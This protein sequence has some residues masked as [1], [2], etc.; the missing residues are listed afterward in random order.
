MPKG[1]ELR[2]GI[3][4]LTSVLIGG[5]IA[6]SVGSE[7]NLFDSKT[8]YRVVFDTV[9]GLR[10]GSPVQIAGVA[11]GSVQSVD[12]TDSGEIEVRFDVLSDAT[13]LIR[14]EPGAEAQKDAPPGTPTGSIASLQGK[15][16]LGDM[17]LAVSVGDRSLP[18]WPAD[19][20]LPTDPSG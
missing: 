3:F 10:A 11:V 6:F 12:F 2:V 8:T 1:T 13:R 16:M 19:E 9:S 17:L 18:A 5:A 20:P 14:G 7:S 15:G 4:V